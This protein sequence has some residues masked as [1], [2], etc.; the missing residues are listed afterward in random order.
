META[1]VRLALQRWK[2]SAATRPPS[3]Q[4]RWG[5]LTWLPSKAKTARG[6]TLRRRDKKYG[7]VWL[8]KTGL[9]L[10]AFLGAGHTPESDTEYS[11]ATAAAVQWLLDSQDP[12]TGAFGVTSSYGHGIATYAL[13]ECYGM[14]KD[15]ALRLPVEAGLSWIARHQGPRR[16]QRNRGGW[17]YFS[18][19]MKSEDSYARSSVTV[20]MV[21]AAESAKLSGIEVPKRILPGAKEMLLAAFDRSRGSF[22]YNH[23]PGRLSSLW[24]T[25]P[26]STPASAFA[27]MLLGREAEDEEVRA[28][29]DYTIDRK[30]DR[31]ARAS[32]DEFRAAG[33]GPRLLLVL[34]LASD[35]PVWRRRLGDVERVAAHRAARGPTGR[36]G[37]SANRRLRR[38]CRRRQRPRRLYHGHVCAQ[39]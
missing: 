10:L 32:Q 36:R 16:D 19:E 14:T 3:A 33:Q 37:V 34:R 5:W 15:E 8:G 9:C 24:P 20:W 29:L 23:R 4:L 12:K 28:A 30:P 21:M 22:R 27:L 13:A 6:E 2:S 18:T 26:A 31:Y 17:G 11:E 7:Q 39:P 38:L 35:V 1:S 25:L